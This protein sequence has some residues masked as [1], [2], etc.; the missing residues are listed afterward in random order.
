MAGR[1]F[2]GSNGMRGSGATMQTSFRWREG[3][4]FRRVFCEGGFGNE[5]FY[6]IRVWNCRTYKVSGG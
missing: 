3:Q 4:G 6:K 2:S 5:P 1:G